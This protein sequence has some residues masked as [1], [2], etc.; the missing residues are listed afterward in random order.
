MITSII[1]AII[2]SGGLL[3]FGFWA[4]NDFEIRRTKK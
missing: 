3:G 2:I 1:I 4:L